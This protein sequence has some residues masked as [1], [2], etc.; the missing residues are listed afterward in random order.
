MKIFEVISEQ[1]NMIHIGLPDDYTDDVWM[2][3]VF[4]DGKLVASGEEFELNNKN[5]NSV[6]AFIRALSK[7]FNVPEDSFDLYELDDDGKNPKLFS[8]NFKPRLGVQESP[9]GYGMRDEPGAGLSKASVRQQSSTMINQTKRANAQ[10]ADSGREANIAANAA[11]RRANRL[12]S[13][14]PTG[15]PSRILNPQ[16]P[17]APEEQ[18]T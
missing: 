11:N 12:R 1:N 2:H 13:K 9:T 4:I 3:R 16:Q 17:Q 5:F 15:I 18:Q 6:D 7:K 8:K 10:A 14:I